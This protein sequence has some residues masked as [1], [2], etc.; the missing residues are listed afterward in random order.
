MKDQNFFSFCLRTL[1]TIISLV[2]VNG[3][4]A[5][6][7]PDFSSI[8]AHFNNYRQNVLQE[9]I[10]VHTDKNTYLAGELVWFKIYNVDASFHKPVDVSKVVYVEILNVENAPVVQT[11]IAIKDGSGHGSFSLPPNLISGNYVFRAYTNWMKNFDADFFFE[12]TISIL[13]TI[14]SDSLQTVKTG[15]KDY[16][17]QFFPEGGNLVNG[18]ESKVGFRIVDDKGIG[19]N[20]EGIILDQQND[21]VVNFSSSKFGIGSFNFQPHTNKNYKAVIKLNNGSLVTKEFP[22]AYDQG[23]V[24][25]LKKMDDGKTLVKITTSNNFNNHDVYLFIHSRQQVV[26]TRSLSIR[27]N[28]AIVLLEESKIQNG[29]SQVTLFDSK[30]QPVCERLIFKRPAQHLL[31]DASADRQQYESRKKVTIEIETKNEAGNT[32]SGEM[33]L[34]VYKFDSTLDAPQNIT[35]YLWLSSDLRGNIESPDYYFNNTGAAADSAR[36]N[37]MLTH[38]WRRFEWK[39]VL[40]HKTYSFSHIPEFDGHFVSGMVSRITGGGSLKNIAGFFA[41]P[42]SSFQFY[43]GHTDSVGR[44]NFY[45]RNFFG[46][47]EVFA[48]AGGR[49]R[50]FRIDIKS[51]F[52]EIFSSRTLPPFLPSSISG[53]ALQANS[54]SM[55]V[56]NIFAADKANNFL[57]PSINT[58]S[59]YVPTRTYLLDNYV[60][61]PT[62]EEVL[63]EYVQEVAVNKENNNLVLA[64]GR[65]DHAGIVYRYEPLVLVDGI[66]LFDDPNKIFSY[67]PLKVKELQI[68]NKKYF[69]GTS[70]FEGILNFKTF[71]GR[72][73]GLALDP[74]ATVLDYEGLQLQRHF[75]QPLYETQNQTASRLPDFRNLLFWAPTIKTDSLGKQTLSFYTSDL[76]G[77][78]M[79][80]I[81]GLS[82][83]GRAGDKSF[84]IE[85]IN[86]LFV[87]N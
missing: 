75:F 28:E 48:Q 18:I 71:E 8:Y 67:D 72:P 20:L 81:K 76:P 82:A 46:P 79:V 80:E 85:V 47:H 36:D 60:R 58:N 41:V 15:D 55:Q 7:S 11:K 52:S 84:T 86:P 30:L 66:P 56:Q 61:F 49:D 37:L 1:L 51:P 57:A 70:S 25:Q 74:N 6:Q 50:N 42:D 87:Q 59:F 44:V 53:H 2:F 4:V 38:G 10:Y 43:T 64:A 54:I 24:L 77:K 31:I 23:Y 62:M 32:D 78:Y 29:I 45:T 65:R 9:K 34:A 13:N 40:K 12:K 33:S 26:E 69:L 19:Q 21:R 5:S 39:D 14:I 16:D 3:K 27:N 83:E 63:R 73:E 68:V 22:K 35:S 17:V